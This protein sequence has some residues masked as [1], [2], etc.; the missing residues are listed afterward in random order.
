MKSRHESERAAIVFAGLFFVMSIGHLIAQ[1]TASISGTVVDSSQG[2]VVG[3]QVTLT[4]VGA[5]QSRIN[6]GSEQGFF[7]FPDLSPGNYKVTVNKSGFK[8]W[9]QSS[10]TLSVAQHITLYPQLQVGAATEQIEVTAQSAFLTTDNSSLAGVVEFQQIEQL[11]LNGRNA[12]QL[13][14]LEP[15]IV[16]T[17]TAGQFGAVQVSFTSSGG[18]DIDTN[19]TLDGG[20]NVDPFYGISNNYPTP[21]AL[22]EFYVSS[23]NSSP[24]SGGREVGNWEVN[25]EQVAT[26]RRY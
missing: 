13:E 4:N 1:G 12:L 10:I 7:E 2:T 22:Q 14:A 5:G 8:A 6:A 15:G 16:S 23:R 17:G 19:Y 24:K 11:P 26:T 9:E 3:S 21:D 20:I 25:A 18:R